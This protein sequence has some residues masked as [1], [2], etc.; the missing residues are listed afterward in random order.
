MAKL[1]TPTKPEPGGPT[2]PGENTFWQTYNSNLE[3]PLA[4][5]ISIFLHGALIATLAVVL[6]WAMT[7]KE[8]KTPVPI[9]LVEGGSDDSGEGDLMAGGVP[10]PL[11]IGQASPTES[12]FSALPLPNEQT[13]PEI[14]QDFQDKIKLDED[15]AT[16]KITPEKAAAYA[17]LSEAIRDKLMPF[18]QDKGTRPGTKSGPQGTGAD[19]TRARSLRWVLR[20]STTSGR[21]Y[22]N[23]L[24]A[25]GAIVIVPVPPENKSAYVFRD[26][27][28][29][30]VG[31]LATDAEWQKLAQ[32]IQFCDFKRDSVVQV[33]TELGLGELKPHMFWAFFPKSLEDRLAEM[34]RSYQNRSADAIEETVFEVR[35]L[36][37]SYDLTVVRQKLK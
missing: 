36:G 22:L 16:V 37:G 21:D 5:A 34:E 25:L 19:A 12:D 11:T 9:R 30:V 18:G 33:T 10:D 27:K 2:E 35:P 6:L 31:E 17:G 24:H 14:T 20:F 8:D 3:F 23:Q 26:L 32:Q 29:P 1:E 13:L 7:G 4:W 28:N 15:L